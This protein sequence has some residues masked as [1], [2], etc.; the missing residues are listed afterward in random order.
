[1]PKKKKILFVI[2]KSNWGG[3]QRYVHDLAASLPSDQFDVAV[4]LGGTGARGAE[5]GELARKLGRKQIRMIFIRS[6]ARN[7]HTWSDIQAFFEL[8]GIFTKEKPDI[9]HLNSSKAGGLGALAARISGVRR[10][11]FTSHGLAY[12]ENRNT[13]ARIIIWILTCT[14][15]CLSTEVIAISRDTYLRGRKLPFCSSRMHLIHNGISPIHFF[16]REQ[17]RAQLTERTGVSSHTND[18]WIGTI[19]ELTKNKGLV[20][21][22]DAARILKEKV[23]PFQLFIIGEGEERPRLQRQITTWRLEDRVH[24]VGFI[25]DAYEHLGAFDIFALTSIKEGLPYVLLEAGQAGCAVVGTRVA[26]ITDIISDSVSG[27]LVEPK[28]S[29]S[30]AATLEQLITE[31]ERRTKLGAEL[32]RSISTD[33]SLEKMV[34][35]TISLYSKTT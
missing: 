27:L 5:F 30:I 9:V 35:E 28:Q 19:S 34:Q 25:P 26:G 20:Y 24:L 21:L 8:I 1:M 4:A 29:A 12:D 16:A 18:V 10:I 23:L 15:F 6:F 3:A 22:I 31:G 17:G 7:I 13:F 32:R 14:T 2:T 33:F 11:I